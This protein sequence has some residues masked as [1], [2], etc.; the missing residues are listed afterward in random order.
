MS[1]FVLSVV[2]CYENSTCSV[3]KYTWSEPT[4]FRLTIFQN[5]AV[6]CKEIGVEAIS[7]IN[8]T[9]HM[10]PVSFTKIL[11]PTCKYNIMAMFT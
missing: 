8:K 3:Y 11:W 7:F 9:N 6:V 10:I 4:L 5:Y 1:D 2:G